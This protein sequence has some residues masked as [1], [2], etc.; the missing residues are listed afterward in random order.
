MKKIKLLYI[1]GSG[2]CGST[3]LDLIIGSA[4]EVFST[5]ELGFYN[6]YKENKI[7]NK[8][9]P[10]YICTC[11]KD[12]NKCEIWGEVNK[13]SNVKI[14]KIFSLL[15]SFKI[16]LFTLFPFLPFKKSDYT[17]D[18]DK[19]L[20]KL[21][22]VIKDE[23]IIYFLDS[24]KDPRRLFY[25]L[26]NPK[27]KV[28]PIHLIREAG[29]VAYSYNK[30]SRTKAGLK[31]KNFYISLLKWLG[32]NLVTKKMLKNNPNKIVIKY[33]D[34]C[35][36]PTKHIKLVNK[37]L[38]INIKTENFLREVNKI[39][40]HNIDGNVLRLKKINEIKYSNKWKNIVGVF[41]KHVSYL[42]N[43]ICLHE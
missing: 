2:H 3:L 18:T 19:L 29:G 16:I 36:N 22:K 41:K 13:N 42:I 15:E 25:L 28:Y 31:R 12:F 17:D 27:I 30:K 37:K 10:E 7:Y 35:E 8:E 38:N 24:S 4:P 26:N 6:I 9:N 20:K 1:V 11:G 33:K 14:K 43:H 21:K 32:I 34:F 5:G 40:Y 39:T 23:D